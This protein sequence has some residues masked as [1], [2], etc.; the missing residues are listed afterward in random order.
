MITHMSGASLAAGVEEVYT[1]VFSVARGH[2]RVL[3][4]SRFHG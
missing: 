2:Y 3:P 1:C 4:S